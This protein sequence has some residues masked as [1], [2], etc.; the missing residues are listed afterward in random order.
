MSSQ[1]SRVYAQMTTVTVGAAGTGAAGGGAADMAGEYWR[2]RPSSA[3]STV[4][5]L[6]MG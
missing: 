3:L 4:V 5:R 6:P 2:R 1:R